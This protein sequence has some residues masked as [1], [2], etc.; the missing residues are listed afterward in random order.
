M[1]NHR[2]LKVEQLQNAD[3]GSACYRISCDDCGWYVTVGGFYGV[4]KDCPEG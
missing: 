4:G 2:N 1:I 3:D